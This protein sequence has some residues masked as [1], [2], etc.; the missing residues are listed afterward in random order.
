MGVWILEGEGLREM[1]R[2]KKKEME[3][4][5]E[6]KEKKERKRKRKTKKR[7]RKRTLYPCSHDLEAEG[8][9]YQNIRSA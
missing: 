3:E 9:E 7:K 5:E 8:S 6:K 2:G 1:R 4:E